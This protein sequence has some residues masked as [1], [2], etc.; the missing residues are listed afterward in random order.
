[1]VSPGRAGA[2]L[3]TYIFFAGR[4]IVCGFPRACGALRCA[5]MVFWPV[6]GAS[7]YFRGADL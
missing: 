1:M 2:L 7:H 4:G 3:R 5:L 6:E